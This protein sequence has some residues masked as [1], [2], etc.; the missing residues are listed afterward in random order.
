M[1]SRQA[2]SQSARSTR[3]TRF[4][5]HPLLQYDPDAMTGGIEVLK[6][7]YFEAETERERE[8]ERERLCTCSNEWEVPL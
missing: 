2:H 7:E 4:D 5:T 3:A 1:T 8:R 6:L